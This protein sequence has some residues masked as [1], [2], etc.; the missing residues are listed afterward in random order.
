M[1]VNHTSRGWIRPG[2]WRE[3]TGPGQNTQASWHARSS[4]AIPEGCSRLSVR[5]SCLVFINER[6]VPQLGEVLCP[7]RLGQR[8]EWQ[9]LLGGWR[10]GS[11]RTPIK[12]YRD[13]VDALLVDT[14][15]RRSY[16]G[17][18]APAGIY[19]SKWGP[20]EVDTPAHIY[21]WRGHWRCALGPVQRRAKQ[22]REAGTG[23]G[24]ARRMRT[25]QK[26][27][28]RDV[29]CCGGEEWIAFSNARCGNPSLHHAT[30]YTA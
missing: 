30:E 27:W 2:L 16:H 7:S 15:M 24:T 19:G 1:E 14:R 21:V 29:V 13:Q 12:R 5:S 20:F 9:W 22:T 23:P 3:H 10:R 28:R 25:T 4:T 8:V 18:A 11:R 6:R 26:E 17:S